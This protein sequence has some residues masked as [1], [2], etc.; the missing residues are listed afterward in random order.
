M[1]RKSVWAVGVAAIASFAM[2]APAHA[3]VTL[4]VDDDGEECPTAAY[5]SVQD[6][7]D[8]ADPGD[9][10]SICPGTYTEGTGAA[11]TNALS[12]TKSLTIRGAGADDVTIQARRT[13]PSGG[14]IAAG[15]PNI[16]DAVGNIVSIAGGSAVPDHRG[17]LR[18]HDRRQRRLFRGRPA[19]TSM[20]RDRSSAAA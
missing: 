16:R 7:V 14:Q 3:A 2:V 5:D 17:H 8:D 20:H 19:S 10:V 9:T 15:S 1:N 4:S 18:C 12:I 6:A 11:G 13:T